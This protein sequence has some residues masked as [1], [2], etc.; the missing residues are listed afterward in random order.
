MSPAAVEVPVQAPVQA[1]IPT[2]IPHKEPLK[3]S[4]ALDAFEQFDVTPVIGRE[5]PKANLVDWINS[6]NADQLLRDLAIT[7]KAR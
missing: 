5:F 6:P 4:G 2:K 1:T 3:A 7:S